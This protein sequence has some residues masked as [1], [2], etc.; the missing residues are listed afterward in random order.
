MKILSLVLAAVFTAAGV[1]AI[2][3]NLSEVREVHDGVAEHVDQDRL[4][5]L[6]A[7]GQRAKA[8][9]EAFDMGDE[10][11][12][13]V[14]NAIDGVGANVG[15][16]QRFTRVPR[17]DL[18]GG[19]EWFNHR[20]IR[21]TGP[22]ANACNSC[23]RAPFDDGSGDASANVHRD[24]FRTGQVGQFIERNTPH[25]FAPGAVQR[26]AE[27]MTDAL[28]ADRQ[29][30][31]EETCRLGGKQ[32]VSLAAKGVS[33]GTLAAT[34]TQASPCKVSFDTSGVRGIDFLPS[35]DN[36]AAGPD[37]IVRPFQWKGSVAFLRDF[38]RGASHN[39]LG[40]QAVEIVGDG[41]D[42]D[43]DGVINEMTI[44]DQTALAVY[45]AAQPRPTT[46]LELQSLG[47]IAP[48]PAAQVSAINRGR[49]VFNA[50]N[51]DSCHRPSLTIDEPTFSEPSQ[52][53]AYRD[54]SAFP[55]G[56]SPAQRGVDPR[57]AVT[58]NLTR[59]QPDNQ[60]PRPDGSV[61]RL[62]SLKKDNSGRAV[63]E[64]F[65]DLRRHEMGPRLA[66]PVNEIAGTDVTPIPLDPRNRHTPGTFLTE[67]LWGV[68]S[69]APYL[70]DGRATTLAEAILEHATNDAN[71]PSEAANERRNYLNLPSGDKKALIAFLENLVLFKVE[72]QA[73]VLVAT[74]AP[75]NVDLTIP[76][77]QSKRRG[78]GSEPRF[79]G[80][81]HK[82]E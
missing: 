28:F 73:G 77:G 24:A 15:T 16:G 80:I 56:Q 53:A 50:I 59:D 21:V 11:F 66:E 38:N 74:I 68:G 23:H 60:I 6:V 41:V 58:F 5:N 8:F 18:R 79:T 34:R 39:E 7:S 27:E 72:E 19:N 32:S 70:H 9:D 48:L 25:L 3:V 17:A 82:V 35:V 49:D 1:F 46:L 71:D 22:N 51:C 52:N 13:T 37:L 63:V 30:L 14:F 64:L 44:G 81:P 45:L 20:P 67:A 75:K 78:T 12:E 4:K 61:F 29:R 43:F 33:F 76:R 26:L 40:M 55:A 10:L 65:S 69:T 36:P 31:V 47:L 62:G 57:F 42:G 54:G 2:V